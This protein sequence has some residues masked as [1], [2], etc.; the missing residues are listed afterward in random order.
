M[1]ALSFNFT[2]QGVAWLLLAIMSLA[3]SY[4][5]LVCRRI[6]NRHVLAVFF[7]CCFIWLNTSVISSLVIAVAVLFIGFILNLLGLIGAGDVKLLGAFS[8][9]I[10]PELMPLVLMIMVV[11]GLVAAIVCYCWQRYRRTRSQEFQEGVPYG[12]PICC[13]CLFGV[14]ASF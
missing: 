10:K 4:D 11:L 5:D 14:L 9:A 13:A 2:L 12:V 6:K 1:Q 7:I 8:V 3:I